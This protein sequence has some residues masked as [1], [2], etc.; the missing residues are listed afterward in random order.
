[1]D[2]S[3]GRQIPFFNEDDEQNS[4]ENESNHDTSHENP[5]RR[6]RRIRETIEDIKNV[7][8][9]CAS[10]EVKERESSIEV[11]IESFSGI[12]L[13]KNSISS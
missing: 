3:S 10:K 11:D 2:S 1:M 8:E 12:Y 4:D 6:E 9:I 7:I 5:E 13:L